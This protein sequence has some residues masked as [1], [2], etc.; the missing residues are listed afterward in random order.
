MI[1]R[2]YHIVLFDGHCNLCSGAV[3]WIIRRDNNDIFRFASLQSPI[4]AKLLAHTTVPTLNSM[5]L[6]SANNYF[7]ESNAAFEVAK[8]LPFP[9]S[10]LGRAGLLLPQGIRNAVYRWVSKNRYRW[11]GQQQ[12]CWVPNP[13]LQAKFLS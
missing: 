4:A 8:L 11:F 12:E 6:I 9:W 2:N 1:N 3:Q 5:V 10:W 7:V 13:A